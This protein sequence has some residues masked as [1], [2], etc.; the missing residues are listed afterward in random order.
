VATSSPDLSRPRAG[1]HGTA[2]SAA[3]RLT[4]ETKQFFKTSEFFIWLVVTVGILIAAN[5]IEGEEGGVDFFNARHAWLLITILSA[6]YFVSRGLAKS[7]SRDPYWENS[8]DNA[9]RDDR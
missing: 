3:N 2:R 9:N 4:T 7:G 5:S 8:G 1:D 6:A